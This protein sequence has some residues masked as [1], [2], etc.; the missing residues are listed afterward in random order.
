[1]E[2]VAIVTSKDDIASMLARRT[3]I[4]CF[5]FKETDML[6]D[7]NTVYKRGDVLLITLNKPL[8]YADGLD[9]GLD[10]DLIIMLS[11]HL[12]EKGVKAFL[13]HA[14]GNWGEDTSY[15]GKPFTLSVTSATA[16]TS[17][18]LTLKELS[19]DFKDWSVSLEVTHHG[20]F[21][22][23]PLIFI[24]F[25][26]D[27][28][29]LGNEKAAEIVA[30]TAISVIEKPRFSKPAIGFGGG[31]YAPTFTRLALMEK[32]SFGHI[33]PKYAL[34]IDQKMVIQAIEKTIE[35]PRLAVIDWKGLKG[36]DRLLIT[37]I[38]NDMGIEWIK[39]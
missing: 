21:S 32:Y 23:K 12:S 14:V 27:V 8:I 15:G 31:H 26:G 6:Y 34:P 36:D 22:K 10:I 33:C 16:L 35:K 2:R 20:P 9:E 1:M 24:E 13:T 39:V 19:S 30:S 38:L 11:K 37:S 7:G 4:D 3:L 28:K 25:G 18:L 5:G 29:E 17:S